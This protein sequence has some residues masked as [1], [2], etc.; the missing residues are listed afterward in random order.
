MLEGSRKE[1]R[2]ISGCNA[3]IL[4]P[5][6]PVPGWKTP[7][8]EYINPLSA[9]RRRLWKSNGF[10]TWVVETEF[11]FLSLMATVP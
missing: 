9:S 1:A 3:R 7:L 4:C 5:L 11:P 2:D 6:A 8:D 10:P